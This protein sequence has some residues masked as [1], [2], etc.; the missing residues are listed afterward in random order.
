MTSEGRAVAR[1]ASVVCCPLA[2]LLSYTEY[3]FLLTILTSKHVHVGARAGLALQLTPVQL[4]RRAS[5]RLSHRL[6]DAG[7]GR[8]RAR[9]PEGVPE[10]AFG[11]L[12]LAGCSHN[13]GF[14]FCL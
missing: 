2:G 10:G 13:T 9:G 12:A 6:Q 5:H 7:R 8:Q 3:L 4:W 11:G 14:S 1:G